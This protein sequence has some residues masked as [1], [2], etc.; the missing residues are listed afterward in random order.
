MNPDPHFYEEGTKKMVAEG[1][2]TANKI[3]AFIRSNAA[4]LSELDPAAR[5]KKVLDFAPAK[6]FNQ[7]HPIV[8]Q[9][10]AV[11]GIFNAAAFRR[12]VAATYGQP[13]NI[14]DMERARQDREFRLHLQNA[15]NA[16]YFKYLL[17]ETNR[18][19]SRQEAHRRY[20]MVVAEMDA[21]SKRLLDRYDQATKEMDSEK[22]R[23]SAEKR[24]EILDLLKE[25][26]D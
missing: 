9:Y 26:V 3:I 21:Q 24:K 22:E 16:L 5:R 15:R 4:R 13:P 20:E 1:L 18:D 23:L 17:I 19:L 12:Y 14:E 25:K 7:V 8:L 10:M 2:E 11:E 6:Q